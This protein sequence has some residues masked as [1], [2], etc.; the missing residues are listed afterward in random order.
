MLYRYFNH[1]NNTTEMLSTLLSLLFF[2]FRHAIARY[3]KPMSVVYFRRVQFKH[4]ENHVP[5]LSTAMAM[6]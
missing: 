6:E 5:V 3:R 2:V 1:V 4:N